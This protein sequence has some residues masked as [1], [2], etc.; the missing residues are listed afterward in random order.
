MKKLSIL[1]VLFFALISCEKEQ[2]EPINQKVEFVT[3]F[4]SVFDGQEHFI[5]NESIKN[6]LSPS[7]QSPL[8][9]MDVTVYWFSKHENKWMECSYPSSV[10]SQITVNNSNGDVKVKMNGAPID[11]SATVKVIIQ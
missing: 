5:D 8:L 3:T 7:S 11:P 9:E 1:S 4:Q 10:V 6:V 2:I